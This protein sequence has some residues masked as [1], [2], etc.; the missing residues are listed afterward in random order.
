M[1]ICCLYGSA[2]WLYLLDVVILKRSQRERIRKK[3]SI[4]I[5]SAAKDPEE[6]DFTT[7]LGAFSPPHIPFCLASTRPHQQT[8]VI[9]QRN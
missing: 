5:L 6:L 2:N 1:G 9:P 8:V 4:V 3:V 7:T